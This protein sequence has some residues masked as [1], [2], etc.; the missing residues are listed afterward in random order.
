MN[1]LHTKARSSSAATLLQFLPQLE[2]VDVSWN[3]LIGGCLKALTSHLHHVSGIRT[4]RLCSC[5][6]NSDDTTALGLGPSMSIIIMQS[7]RPTPCTDPVCV[8][9]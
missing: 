1:L 5:R 3:E 2:E 4:L 7:N 9:R 8:C 6:L